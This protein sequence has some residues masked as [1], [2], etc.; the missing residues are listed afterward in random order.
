MAHEEPQITESGSRESIPTLG[1]PAVPTPVEQKR[2]TLASLLDIDDD[3]LSIPLPREAPPEQRWEQLSLRV[4]PETGE[5]IPSSIRSGVASQ[6]PVTEPDLVPGLDVPGAVEV[7]VYLAG[8]SIE[9]FLNPP[10]SSGNGRAQGANIADEWTITGTVEEAPARETESASA[11]ASTPALSAPLVAATPARPLAIAATTV[12]KPRRRMEPPVANF[13]KTESSSVLWPSKR[14]PVVAGVAVQ[15]CAR[16]RAPFDGDRCAA[17]GHDTPIISRAVA[18][19]SAAQKF[20]AYFI[21]SES[22]FLRTLGALVFAPGELTADYLSGHRRRYFSPLYV[23]G[24]AALVFA[25]V[26][27]VASLRPRPDRALRIGGDRT[28]EVVAG[29]TSRVLGSASFDAPQD[30]LHD[31]ASTLNMIPVLWFPV[32][33]F[34]VVAIIAALRITRRRDGP[35]EMVYAAHFTGWFVIWWAVA[36]PLLL[37][38]TRFGFE[39]FAYLDGVTSVRY[40]ED[41]QIAGLSQQWNALRHAVARPLVH[42]LLLA[43]GT[44]PWSILAYRRA[45]DESWPA[46]AIAGVLVAAVPLLL[47]APFA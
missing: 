1:R 11:R 15:E 18:R 19:R 26:S 12:R 38:I 25:V 30:L 16:C 40:I 2:F 4:T 45:F 39:Y 8:Q 24:A 5:A 35:A 36:V 37:L 28:E 27:F 14:T 21:E 3:D 33:T 44:V 7:P 17:C 29:L 43:V 6:P 42:S 34:G 32:M 47:L 31:A 46:A 9:T 23:I 10:P 20:V 22:R 13:E 41:G